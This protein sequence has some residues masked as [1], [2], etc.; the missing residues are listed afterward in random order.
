MTCRDPAVCVSI[1]GRGSCRTRW[2]APTFL[3][4]P[5]PSFIMSVEQRQKPP[6]KAAEPAGGAGDGNGR[7]PPG[8]G[9]GGLAVLRVLRHREFALFWVGQSISLVGT[10]M[11][12]FAQGFVIVSLTK[13]AF[14]LGLVNFAMS[15]P[16]LVLMPLGGV[17]ADRIERRRILF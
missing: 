16:T 11:Q 9:R 10:W 12:A 8:S 15:L 14:A 4:L 3:L 6:R 17:A 7:Q 13:S 2:R 5:S 1:P